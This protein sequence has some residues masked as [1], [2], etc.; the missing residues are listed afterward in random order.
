MDKRCRKWQRDYFN[1]Y[2]SHPGTRLSRITASLTVMMDGWINSLACGGEVCELTCGEGG[3]RRTPAMVREQRALPT[4][5]WWSFAWHKS[6]AAVWVMVICRCAFIH[7]GLSHD[8]VFTPRAAAYHIFCADTEITM[9][10]RSHTGGNAW[11]QGI[12]GK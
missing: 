5:R 4:L 11:N 12:W 6:P 7:L 8:G 3:V 1:C 2:W 9:W 10:A